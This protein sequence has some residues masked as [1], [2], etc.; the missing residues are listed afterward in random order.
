MRI[1]FQNR[2]NLW[3]GGDQIQAQETIKAL[4]ERGNNV[5][6][7]DEEEPDLSKYDIVHLHHLAGYWTWYQYLNCKAQKKP[8]VLFTMYFETDEQVSKDE[9][10]EIYDNASAVVVYGDE[11]LKRMERF[12]NLKD[13]HTYIETGVSDRFS[14]TDKKGEYVVLAARLSE[15][16]NA[17]RAIEA[18]KIADVPLKIYG[19]PSPMEMPYYRKVRDKA[20]IY[21][22]DFKD[23][24]EVYHKAQ[25][26]LSISL[27][28]QDP[29]NF[30]EGLACGC[31]TIL[32]NTSTTWEKY[33]DYPNVDI[34]DPFQEDDNVLADKIKKMWEQPKEK[35]EVPSW[36]DIAKVW[37]GIY[38]KV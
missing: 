12:I 1:L 21:H 22:A 36:D 29:L 17:H 34:F 5:E 13:K 14:F 38:A 18:C 7:S 33:K 11:E 10:Q 3:G 4:N 16:K 32:A 27:K 8:Y 19:Y 6:F 28:E 30:K 25:V 35:V 23:M 9:Q 2:P 20:P 24:P 37:E 26:N 15:Q 31:N